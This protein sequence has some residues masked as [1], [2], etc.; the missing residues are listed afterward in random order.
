MILAAFIALALF[1]TQQASPTAPAASP[2]PA[3]PIAPAAPAATTAVTDPANE[4]VCRRQPIEGSRRSERVCHTRAQWDVIREHARGNRDQA[5][6][7]Q[8]N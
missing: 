7:S 4:Q 8:R 5:S 1:G 2:A 6:Q 3:S